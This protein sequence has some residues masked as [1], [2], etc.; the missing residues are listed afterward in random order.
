MMRQSDSMERGAKG[1]GG[2]MTTGF[3]ISSLEDLLTLRSMI[4]HYEA[5][6]AFN[7]DLNVFVLKHKIAE[8]V[9]DL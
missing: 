8:A 2:V 1:G 3:N 6:E 5:D 4:S 9:D 7:T